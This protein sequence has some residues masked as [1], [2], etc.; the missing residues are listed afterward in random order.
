MRNHLL[1][2]FAL[3]AVQSFSQNVFDQGFFIDENN[4]RVNCQI[5]AFDWV[6]NPTQF[7]YKLSTDEPVK[8]ATMKLVKEFGVDGKS[9][10]IRANVNVDRSSKSCQFRKTNGPLPSSRPTKNLLVKKPSKASV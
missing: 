9:K 2:L 5:K 4:Q 6:N 10:Y 1:F 8:T 3:C 7:E